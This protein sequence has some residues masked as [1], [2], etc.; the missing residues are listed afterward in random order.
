MGSVAM[1]FG[2]LLWLERLANSKRASEAQG[3]HTTTR[4]CP[5]PSQGLIGA[6]L[7]ELR[8]MA[9][10]PVSDGAGSSS[11]SVLS[12]LATGMVPYKA[13]GS[14]HAHQDDRVFPRRLLLCHQN[15]EVHQRAQHHQ[16]D[17]EDKHD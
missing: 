4:V 12:D 5:S 16:Q 9:L 1:L 6:K 11:P 10:L 8:M 13:E 14:V 15:K 17:G 3:Y 2:P 7:G